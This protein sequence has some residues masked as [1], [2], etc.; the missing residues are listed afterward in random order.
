MATVGRRFPWV[1]LAATRLRSNHGYVLSPLRG[2]SGVSP[3]C[4][5]ST[6]HCLVLS[7]L[8]SHV[9]SA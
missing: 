2:F 5:T 1:P 8:S 6:V 9:P 4:L 7:S 3:L